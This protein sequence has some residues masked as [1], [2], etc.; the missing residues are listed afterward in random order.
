MLS[1]QTGVLM[2]TISG[3]AVLIISLFI[4]DAAGETIY[5]SVDKQGNVTY[6]NIPSS[7]NES[8]V[9]VELPAAPSAESLQE[10]K[11]RNSEIQRAAKEAQEK[12]LREKRQKQDRIKA[13][14]KRL[15]EAEARLDKAKVIRDEDRESLTNGKR[16]IRSDYF[17]RVKQAKEAVDEARKA[18]SEAS[19]Y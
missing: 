11:Q 18:L 13:A 2:R 5:R 19:G 15:Q 17:A 14:E 12:R 7:V 4:Q 8:S 10:S 1:T 6:T 3:I 16:R 9:R